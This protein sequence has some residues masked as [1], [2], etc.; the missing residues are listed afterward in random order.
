M[1]SSARPNAGKPLKIGQ[2]ARLCGLGVD[3]LRFYERQGLIPCPGRTHAGYR[4]Y[5]ET[6][7]DQLD[8]IRRAQTLG[9][10]LAEIAAVIAEKRSGGSPCASVRNIVRKRLEEVDA[11]ISELV[12]YRGDL[13]ATLADW[14]RRG[15]VEGHVCGLVE[16]SAI[17]SSHERGR[18][19]PSRTI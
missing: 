17:D 12:Q 18:R 5:D 3:T 8:F 7:L 14:D 16:G 15:D 2:V 6:V 9:F 11:R 4:I 13:A 10:S 19:Q 1:E